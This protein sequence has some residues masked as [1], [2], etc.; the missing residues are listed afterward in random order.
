M[1]GRPEGFRLARY[2]GKF[3]VVW[4]ED[5]KRHRRSLGTADPTHAR[6]ALGEF[7]A[8]RER[9]TKPQR[10][11]VAA[12][13]EAYETDR[14]GQVA[15]PGAIRYSIMALLPL[16]GPLLPEHITESQ[17]RGYVRARQAAGRKP[18]T[19]RTELGVLSTAL[20]WA[21]R[22]GWIAVAPYV[23]RPRAQP[24]RDRHLNRDEAARL[25][26]AAE[27]PHVKLF[28]LLAL[29]SAGGAAALLEL[30][31]DRVDL[32]NNLIYLDAGDVKVGRPKGRATVP[33]TDTLRAALVEAKKGALLV[34]RAPAQI[35]QRPR[36]P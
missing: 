3:A 29:H 1:S 28:I 12:I 7:I 23:H 10:M 2:R 5:G 15:S 36:I 35:R 9:N 4:Y 18:G 21:Q 26:A 30:T 32:G 22:K 8:V 33:L 6:T 14:V 24:P 19:A 27:Q 31:W 16:L 25:I 34:R 20:H 11:T 13:L 17:C